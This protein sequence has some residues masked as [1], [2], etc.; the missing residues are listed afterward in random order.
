MYD[1]FM[2]CIYWEERYPR[3]ITKKFLKNI[4]QKNEIA[5][6]GDISV[7]INGAIE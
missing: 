2:N 3:L 5:D 4:I 1:N 7:D 6:I